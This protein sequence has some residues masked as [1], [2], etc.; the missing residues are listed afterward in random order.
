MSSSPLVPVCY[1]HHLPLVNYRCP[2]CGG[3][4]TRLAR[5]VYEEEDEG[6]APIWEVQGPLASWHP[7]G[8]LKPFHIPPGKVCIFRGPRGSGK[9]SLAMPTLADADVVANEMGPSDYVDFRRR[10]AETWDHMPVKANVWEFVHA[11][12][13]YPHLLNPVTQKP[14]KQGHVIGLRDPKTGEEVNPG[15]LRELI[16]DSISNT[17]DD[18]QAL[19]YIVKWA[20]RTGGRAIVILWETSQ[21]ES[22]GGAALPHLAWMECVLGRD[23]TGRR[24]FST[25][26]DRS[27]RL[28]SLIFS[29][30]GEASVELKTYVSVEGD[31]PSYTLRPWPDFTGWSGLGS[32]KHADV[33]KAVERGKADG[34]E[35]PDP[36]L[37]CA[38]HQSKL[39]K[40]GWAEPG[41]WRERAAFAINAGAPYFSPVYDRVFYELDD[42]NEVA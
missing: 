28:G 3:T 42:L 33:F 22:W 13:D 31:P 6:E 35:L 26:K 14:I 7:S 20:E 18:R 29:L 23:S 10:L 1:L 39:Y 41:D 27:N 21:G 16:V 2:E 11:E 36:P 4:V 34:L 5:V 30:P 19:D 25:L 32:A 38:A 17:P 15:A 37:A 40:S 8:S 24:L 12:M 9:T